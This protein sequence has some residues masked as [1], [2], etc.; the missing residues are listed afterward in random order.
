[1]RHGALSDL[2][3][4]YLK[5][6]DEKAKSYISEAIASYKSG[7]YRSAIVATWIA[8]CFDIIDKFREL[9]IA[10]DKEAE[11]QI[12]LLS[13]IT[14]Q[15]DVAGALRFEKSLLEVAR[16]KFE[17]ISPLESVDLERIY[18]DRNRCAH[19]SLVGEDEMYTPSAELARTHIHSAVSHLLQ[20]PPAQGRYA[21]T[22]L[23]RDV[24]SEIFPSSVE[25]IEALL[26]TGILR[27][28]RESLTRN[29][30]TA[31]LKRCL[32][33]EDV[34]YRKKLIARRTLGVVFKLHFP[35]V[36]AVFREKLSQMGRDLAATELQ[37]MVDLI[38]EIPD[39]WPYLE[40]D[41]NIRLNEFVSALP[42]EA[43]E[44]LSFLLTF[45]PLADAAK[46]RV[47]KLTLTEIKSA[48]FLVT[49]PAIID[50]AID[51]YLRSRSFE[52]ANS[53]AKV[54]TD[55]VPELNINQIG[56]LLIGMAANSEI[57]GSFSL[58][59]LLQKIK[60]SGR[61]ELPASIILEKIKET[62]LDDYLDD[63]ADES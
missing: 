32:T 26:S 56:R 52:S 58:K 16:E 47:Q 21:L 53:G 40:Q 49:P 34:D 46:V 61:P 15:G 24:D 45:R 19:P 10:G 3:E 23:L 35:V 38:A 7:A 55:L 13:G 27:K 14:Q 28:P 29:F 62:E 20:H 60:D 54:I 12:S 41:V 33:E 31:L 42:A 1:M 44:D 57:T 11:Q 39:C 5:C 9:S 37:R 43:I 36:E 51:L 8:V 25:K 59:P 4:L 50:K 30:A 2:D 22:R 48:L 63:D 18:A 17:L 6:R